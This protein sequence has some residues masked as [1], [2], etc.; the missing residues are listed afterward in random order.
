MSG[1]WS[2]DVCSSDL[3]HP[4]PHQERASWNQCHEP[5]RKGAAHLGARRS[6]RTGFFPSLIR[7]ALIRRMQNPNVY[8]S[9][10]K[11]M[12]VRFFIHSRSKRADSIALVDSGA[13]E[14]FMNL[15][16]ARHLQL[17]IQRLPEPHK[18]FNVDGTQNKAGVL[19]YYTDLNVQTGGNRTYLR[20][21]LSDLGEIGRAHV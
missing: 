20:F 9:N 17:P 13:T 8:I 18:L 2:S 4:E 7:S 6:R 1:D 21:F 5:R 12:T 15:Q 19:E 3:P 14:N 16:Y 11:S 10:R